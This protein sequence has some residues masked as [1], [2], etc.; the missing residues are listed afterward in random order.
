MSHRDSKIKAVRRASDVE[1]QSVQIQAS[2]SVDPGLA[3]DNHY[4]R[5]D[6]SDDYFDNLRAWRVELQPRESGGVA[7]RRSFHERR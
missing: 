7:S 1:A 4:E 2:L 6:M 3:R 5:Y